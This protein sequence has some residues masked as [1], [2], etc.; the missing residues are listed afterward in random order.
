MPISEGGAVE[1]D[2][3]D[4]CAACNCF[5]NVN[6]SVAYVSL[7]NTVEYS[8]MPYQIELDPCVACT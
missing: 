4:T 3:Q 6:V 5:S 7:S 2:E 1:R 8:C